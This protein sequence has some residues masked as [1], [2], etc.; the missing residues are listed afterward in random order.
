MD[1]G[2]SELVAVHQL[3]QLSCRAI[4]GDLVVEVRNHPI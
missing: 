2:G 4:K 1:V 3:Q